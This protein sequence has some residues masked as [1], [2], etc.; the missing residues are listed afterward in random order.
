[1]NL[2]D[3]DWNTYSGC[4]TISDKF[5]EL[6]FDLNLA[7]IVIG[8]THRARNTLDIAPTNFDA[9]CHADAY[10]NLLAI[11]SSDHYMIILTIEH[12]IKHYPHPNSMN[13]GLDY[14][15]AY[16]ENM[17]QFLYEYDF[18]LALSSN[19]TEFIWSYIKMAIYSSMDLFIPKVLIRN[20]NQPR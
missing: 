16:W 3:A 4:S 17:N 9:L 2:P 18:T 8:P 13:T 6:A 15:H 12:T 20:T 5:T 11:L 10:T 19:N 7:Q 14:N 1:M